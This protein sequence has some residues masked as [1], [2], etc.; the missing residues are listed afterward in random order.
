M[1]LT[2]H[3]FI[4]ILCVSVESILNGIDITLIYYHFMCN[5]L[6]CLIYY[7]SIIISMCYTLTLTCIYLQIKKKETDKEKEAEKMVVLESE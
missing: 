6:I 3:L 2:L 4:I 5:S 7:H 1:E